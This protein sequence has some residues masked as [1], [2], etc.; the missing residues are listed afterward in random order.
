MTYYIYAHVTEGNDL[1]IEYNIDYKTLLKNLQL[2]FKVDDN[3]VQQG[4]TLMRHHL[5]NLLNKHKVNVLEINEGYVEPVQ[6]TYFI[7]DLI[8]LLIK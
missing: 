3:I 8:K 4:D 2:D 6:F 7:N 5:I 1:H